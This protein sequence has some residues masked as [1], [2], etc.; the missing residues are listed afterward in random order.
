MSGEGLKYSICSQLC[1]DKQGWEGMTP[2]ST[3]SLREDMGVGEGH[4]NA[5]APGSLR[6]P[7]CWLHTKELLKNTNACI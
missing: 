6:S 7:A 4:S 1:A 2:F 5:P 3:S